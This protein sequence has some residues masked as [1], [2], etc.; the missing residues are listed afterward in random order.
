MFP[1]SKTYRRT[2]NPYS[3]IIHNSTFFIWPM[4]SSAVKW[5]RCP[6]GVICI[7]WHGGVIPIESYPERWMR[8]ISPGSIVITA[9]CSSYKREHRKEKVS[10]SLWAASLHQYF[11]SIMCQPLNLSPGR[12]LSGPSAP[13]ER[14]WRIR[15]KLSV[16]LWTF[17]ETLWLVG[18]CLT[19]VTWI[20][21]FLGFNR[22]LGN[23][24]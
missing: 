13:E 12:R 22:L 2:F 15:H 18:L 17:C 20:G 6:F 11:F 24:W 8:D 4:W 10:R 14:A 7:H 5:P 1:I 19:K 3:I 21:L 23:H 16:S 9:Y